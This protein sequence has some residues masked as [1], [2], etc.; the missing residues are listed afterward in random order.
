MLIS[1]IK[2]HK[3]LMT[4]S[5]TKPYLRKGLHLVFSFLTV[6]EKYSIKR[7]FYSIYLYL[8]SSVWQKILKVTAK[9]LIPETCFRFL[10]KITKKAV[11]QTNLALQWLQCVLRV[12]LIENII[13]FEAVREPVKDVHSVQRW[14]GAHIG[15]FDY[16]TSDNSVELTCST[17]EV[18]KEVHWKR[19]K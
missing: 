17:W 9:L 16:H 15:S 4:K 2:G 14:S 5:K 3:K 11:S 19:K 7:V 10:H 12:V 8:Y 18:Q 13:H 6:L 1:A